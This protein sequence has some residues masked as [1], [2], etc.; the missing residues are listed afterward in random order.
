MSGL[1]TI[2][3]IFI[4][5][6][7]AFRMNL[8][9]G[10]AALIITAIA[11][12]KKYHTEY[13]VGRANAE[14]AKKN[15]DKAFK[16]YE[17]AYKSKSRKFT[18]DISYALALT[19]AGNPEK[20]LKIINDILSLRVTDEIKKKAKESRCIIN[21]RLG[22]N[23]EAY[24]EATELFDEGYR[25]SNMYC[26][27][28]YL[29]LLL[30]HPIEETYKFCQKAYEYDSDNRDNVDNLAV[31]CLR[32]GDYEKAAEL[33]EELIENFPKFV[34]GWYHAALAQE[35]L[36]NF[37]KAREYAGKIKD[38]DRTIMTTISESEAENLVKRLDENCDKSK[39]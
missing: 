18:V 15:Y 33:G 12:Y 8:F 20:A 4:V 23:E 17:K 2:L 22:N 11:I 31:C 16:Y 14:F 26:I 3:L 1:F 39:R 36:G 6:I 27:I 35:K 28:G 7:L 30:N 24:E 34:E 9:L 5:T 19:R 32:L 29:K 21:Y 38:C 25:T 37:K 10:I 13:L